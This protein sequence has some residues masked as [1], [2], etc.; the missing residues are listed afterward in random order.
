MKKTT[1][2]YL[3]MLTFLLSSS[4]LM[5]QMSPEEI[6]FHK[7]I[8]MQKDAALGPISYAQNPGV[9]VPG[10][11][12][13]DPINYGNVND[14]SQSGSIVSYG[15]AWYE[16]TGA[17][18]FTVT[19]SLCASDYDTKV[20]VWG[21]C[22]DASYLFY[23]DD[24][25]GVQSEIAGIPFTAGSTMYVKVYGFS[26]SYGNYTLEITGAGPP[27]GPTPITAFPFAENF[28]GGSLPAEMAAYTAPESDVFVDAAAT[29][30]GSYGV[31]MEGNSSTGWTG[32]STSTTYD[33]AWNTNTTH[34]GELALEVHPDVGNPGYL[35]MSFDMRQNYSFGWA[36]EFFRVLVNGTPIS[37]IN[38]NNSWNAA[39]ANGDPWQTLEF[40]LTAY[41][42]LASFDIA[43][44]NSGKYYYNYYGGGDVAMVDNFEI[45]YLLPGDITGNV[46][47]TAGL[48][49]GGAE[50]YVDGVL[51]ATTDGT[52][53]YLI[54]AIPNG[55]YELTCMKP[56]YNTASAM[57]TAVGGTTVTQNF[58]LTAPN[59][60]VSPLR[61]DETLAPN[62][63]L[64]NY[65]G[66]L[67]TGSGPVD[68]TGMVVYPVTTNAVTNPGQGTDFSA[69]TRFD[70]KFGAGSHIPANGAPMNERGTMDC[71]DGSVFSSAPVGSDDGNT[72]D[73]STPYYVAQSFTG[74]SSTVSSVTFWSIFT[75]APP[76]TKDY[77]IEI[78]EA[79]TVP[80]ALLSSE[81]FT[82]TPVNTGVQVLGYDTY[83]FTAEITPLAITDGW[84]VV[85]SV[86]GS[87]TNYWLNTYSG[88]G[89]AIQWTGSSYT[90]LAA[91]M[92]MCLGGGGAGNWLTLGQYDGS[93][94]GGGA[95]FNLPV[96]FDASGT[97]VGDF[98]TADIVL[99][100]SPDVGTITIPVTMAIAG[101]PIE[102]VENLEV[103]LTNDITGQVTLTWSHNIQANFLYFRINRNSVPI[104]TSQT[105][106]FVNM[107]P[108]YGNFCY[109]V[110]AVY[111]QGASV[112]AGPECIEWAN[113][114]LTLVD[115]PCYDELWPDS[116]G[117]DSFTIRNTGTGTMS[118]EFPAYVT[119][120]ARFSGIYS[121]VL[122]DSYGDGWNGGSID[123]YV[124]GNL[125][126]DNVTLA[127]GTGPETVYFPVEGGD[128][129]YTTYVA[130]SY[131]SEISY[132]IMD[133]E[134]NVA[135]AVGP[136]IAGIPQGTL[137][138]VVPTPS[139]IMD[140]EPAQGFIPAGGSALIQLTYTSMGFPIGTYLEDLELVTN[141][142]NAPSTMI[143]NTMVVYEPA[144]IHGEVTDCNTGLGMPGVTVTASGTD[145]STETDEDGMYELWVDDGTYD[146]DFTKL[147]FDGYTEPG[148]V[149]VVGSPVEV[150]AV[151]CEA[152][153]PVQ[154]V[155]AD[156]N[157]ADT[158]CM[159]TWSLPMGPYEIAYD[160]GTV[161]EY[162]MWALPGG[163]VAVRFTPVGYP[164]TAIGGRLYVGDGSFPANA[165]FL[166]SLMAVG[167]ID[168]DG[169]NGMPGTVLDSITTTVD[170][171]GW[172]EFY[173]LNAT[174]TDG[175]FYLVM[176]QLG[177]SSTSAP[178]GIDNE[179]PIVYRSYAKMPNSPSW[180]I[181]P[182]Q[183]F[184]MRAYVSGPTNSVVTNAQTTVV[185]LPKIPAS[186]MS[187]FIASG[188]PTNV[189]GTVKSGQILPIANAS[190]SG[191]RD[192]S[193]YIVA[194][195]SDFDP[196]AGPE[197][198]TLTSIASPSGVTFY[199]DAAFG[200]QPAGFYAYA[201]KSIYDNGE[202][203]WVYSNT[204]A[205][206]LSA[207]IT[208]NV[209][210]CDGES[211]EGTEVSLIGSEYPYQNLF[212][213]AGADGTVVFDSVIY[214][215]YELSVFH[216][217][218]NP[219]V[220]AITVSGDHVY[221]LILS[222]KEYMPR[223]LFVDA[224]TSVA[225]W[226]EPLIF[227]MA[228]EGFESTTF[229]P[230]G[231]QA[232]SNDAGG[233][234]RGDDGGSSYFPIP[235]GDG[236]YAFVN[237]DVDSNHDGAADY[238]ITPSVDLRESPTFSLYYDH[239]FTGQFGEA[240]Y[241]E[242]SL[243]GGA[244]WDIL[245]S[246][247]IVSGWTTEMVDL[248]AFS[249][250]GG[251]SAIWFAFHYDD[252]GQWAAGW[253]VDNVHVTN[254]P[255]DVVAYQVELDGAFMAETTPDVL[256]HT[257]TNLTYGQ[258]Y[259]AGVRAVYACGISDP[260]EYTWT[261]GYLYP[262]RNLGDEYVYGT[263]EVP[264]MWNPP[265]TEPSTLM[266][267]DRSTYVP[268][269]TVA[270]NLEDHASS[271]TFNGSRDIWDILY[272]FQME[273]P[274]GLTGLA[275]AETD[276]EF[277]YA[278]VWSSNNIV[279]F[280]TD[281]TYIE[282]FTIPGVT[283]L[284]DL[285]FDGTYFYGGAA[286]T[287]VFEMDFTNHTLVSSFTAP[288]ACRAIAY[289][290]D[291]DGF[292]AN[293]WDTD[294]TLFSR[295]GAVLSTISG[296]PSIYGLAYDNVSD[297]GPFLW[298]FEG[299]SSGGGCWISQMDIA[300]GSPTG[301]E[302]SVSNDFG[303]AG[304]AGGLYFDGDIV[305]GKWT[306]GGTM[307]GEGTPAFG[308]DQGDNSG[309]PVSGNVP[310]GLVSFILYQD[311]EA[312]AEIP[313]EG[314]D[315]DA[316]VNYVINPI[317]PGTYAFDVSAKYDLTQF[318]FPGDF[319]ES[320][321]EGT[322]IVHV[323]WG[324]PVPFFEGWDQ[325]T[326]VF[327]GWAT[328]GENWKINPVVGDPEPS[329]E[330]TWDPLL[331]N[332]YSSSLT[333][334]PITADLMTEGELWLDFDVKLD[335]RNATGEEMLNVEVY[336]GTDWNTVATFAN[337]ESFDFTGNHINITGYTMSRVFKVR[338]NAV[339]QNSFDVISWFVDNIE[340]YRTCESISDLDVV[341][342]NLEDALLSW[343]AP[344]EPVIADWLY[345][346][347]GVNVDGIGGPASFSWAIK[348]DPSQ[349][350]AYAGASL[351]KISIYNR[352]DATDELRIYKGTNAATL[353]HTQAL[354]GLGME[355]WE[356]VT[357]TTPVMLDVT[358]ELWITVYTTDGTNYPAACGNAM[359]EPNG[360]LI[361]L[362]GVLWEHLTDYDLMNTW[363]LR[364]YVTDV[365]GV[366]AA[367]PM[368]KPEDVY[369]NDAS[370][371]IS[372]TGSGAN[373]VLNMN[374][375][376]ARVI[377]GFNVY[378]KT[379]EGA[380]YEMF[381]YVP[382]ETGV[383]AY[384][385][386]D[387]TTVTGEGYWY[388][389]TCVWESETDY[390]E[391]MPGYNVPMTEDFVYVLI[392]DVN[393]SQASELSLYPNPASDRVTVSSNVAMNGVTVMNY[394]GQV[395]YSAK[396]AGETTLTLNTA[397]YEA[398]VYV[399]QINTANGVVT[400]R[401]VIAE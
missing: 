244:T 41:Q 3:M 130:G 137:Y 184:M 372:G 118:F 240:A 73:M 247:G 16:F 67:N 180:S 255:A 304:I 315:V 175:D 186:A 66:M 343:N 149:A 360:D 47:N 120:Q 193:N 197:T 318:G 46:S 392:L 192:L 65:L 81:T 132:E 363:N 271:A 340:I 30:S 124:A 206:L 63:Y 289:D 24:A 330:F 103:N 276:G 45:A 396:V 361:T 8:E 167:V 275:G 250:P 95:S 69:M 313:Y 395:V 235:A 230:V 107:L 242:F 12:C 374:T 128:E 368:D 339:G 153:Y 383:E 39:T 189:S 114:T 358:Q 10:D 286:A 214:G 83:V 316:W 239:Y 155:F 144:I 74:V 129:I 92:S 371:A 299:T 102:P 370:L 376:G 215:R 42:N 219:I 150:N 185:N 233:W 210:L 190:A 245:Q 125:V 326:F 291:A 306:L 13:T 356:E 348:F 48:S 68:W 248:S 4:F 398:G 116:Y 336:N 362:D 317:D 333:S 211:P 62:E 70:G 1:K 25:C 176:W 324:F 379:S 77:V 91:Q 365:T 223:N 139:F 261:S 256:T 321:W 378:R 325:G 55:D 188:E 243:D 350:S 236:F 257:F 181:S 278:T 351:T 119:T 133:T 122:H 78:Y 274:S 366:T 59:L 99:T 280:A 165:N 100:T 56:G 121:V 263:N 279:K 217:G 224:S 327:N 221:D 143:G 101:D 228:N 5:A 308:Y 232:L 218:Y 108:N 353:L 134:D 377:A 285:A 266:A 183:D 393:N 28:D 18:D 147:G 238:L 314:Q 301:V 87:P 200:G 169:T 347:D 328:D 97:E 111:Q 127:S 269:E 80:G 52:G 142:P 9:R 249:G 284:R 294:L 270:T 88:A 288:T 369:S 198:G 234:E 357:L 172:V 323:V 178:I 389:V 79:G 174:I 112:P 141:D 254:G 64:T 335:N 259:T 15:A 384:T 260:V 23:N 246:V 115:V 21:D 34:I 160:D 29:Q 354:S 267:F 161:D 136:P 179:Q 2:F 53:T 359:G 397:S 375:E 225:T 76:A 297:G 338:F 26:S 400:K 123:I 85:K 349:L 163:A 208:I 394:V 19:V 154:W 98:Y 319:G 37:D 264:L 201:V 173:G 164:A 213:V 50:I 322:D 227:S 82:L 307:Q 237:D 170:N 109:T 399:V 140:V 367:L 106:S 337:T 222:E 268:G 146:I 312:I 273:G 310:D 300:T 298:M 195:V 277:I 226:E 159:V 303:S 342:Y 158:Q 157:Q 72:S 51:S 212:A 162:T 385:Y 272:G 33:Q 32:G 293:N 20:E 401:V 258:T 331:E 296:P 309:G 58:V 302:H 156:P 75:S 204:V 346:D 110:Q 381:D 352:T 135:Y 253:A 380:D 94:N 265:M 90:T 126:L 166:G 27:S 57:V 205:H 386:L 40:D 151:L 148:V 22:A 320:P 202:S 182:Y 292:W 252:M 71:P 104:G 17:T 93:I 60:T 364:G 344:V 341:E 329:A 391:S 194:R 332:D 152:P 89:Q 355:T 14:P 43:I 7:Q 231:W 216:V 61:M 220:F 6:A 251:S 387:E 287:T 311:G 49:I 117:G 31:M 345:Y 241:V 390:C 334:N 38:G 35:K 305:T 105:T 290:E 281:G 44:Q 382:A 145:W 373:S 96:N 168:D 209:S 262:P 11:A 295:S 196:N 131:P 388:Q 199:N 138:A 54:S 191:D 282:T 171:Y 36:Y 113:P 187:S 229:P 177:T 207:E 84:V 86:T 203:E 283:G